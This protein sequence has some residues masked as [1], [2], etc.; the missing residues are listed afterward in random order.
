MLNIENNESLFQHFS[1][2]LSYSRKPTKPCYTFNCYFIQD[3][4]TKEK[5]FRPPN[6]LIPLAWK[7]NFQ[8]YT[9]PYFAQHWK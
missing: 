8:A 5:K 9:Y 3:I 7:E 2:V 4:I 6:P 1:L